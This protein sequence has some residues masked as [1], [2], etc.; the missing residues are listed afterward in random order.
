[1]N[2][3]KE[4]LAPN[5]TPVPNVFFDYWMTILS[6]A[7]FKIL[8]CICRK[9]FGWHKDKD[10]ISLRQIVNMTELNKSTVV[11][12]IDKLIEFDLVLKTKFKD[13]LDGSDAPNQY[14]ILVQENPGGSSLK[15]HPP[16]VSDDSPRV[17]SGDTQK[18]DLTK[19]RPTKEREGGNVDNLPAHSPITPE[20]YST[21]DNVYSVPS[22]ELATK[23]NFKLH[24]DH[25]RLKTGEYEK[26][27]DEL[28]EELTNYYIQAIN[29]YV[30]NHKPYKD[31]AAV[32]R[33]WNLR[34]K[35]KDDL[36]NLKKVQSKPQSK[37]FFEL[38][39]KLCET[40]ERKLSRLFTSFVFFQAGSTSANLYHT[41]KDIQKVYDYTSYNPKEL[42]EILLKDLDMVFPGALNILLDRPQQKISNMINELSE[43]FKMAEAS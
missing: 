38:N 25:V 35:A 29:N 4:V 18:K 41:Q 28:G 14:E 17:V 22:E 30:P 8:L 27:C 5:F 2:N 20:K 10:R 11:K 12:G 24:G 36:P 1:M 43:K 33:Q 42:K 16:V 19:E 37:Q 34:D 7:E 3:P 40:A 21:S 6:P 9:T 31:Y 15:Q 32:I 39:K 13:E 23:N 26:L